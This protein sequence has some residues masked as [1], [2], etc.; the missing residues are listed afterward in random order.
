MLCGGV[1][2]EVCLVL[3]D[4]FC[5]VLNRAGSVM[6]IEDLHRAPHRTL[7]AK[8]SGQAPR[9]QREAIR[10]IRV[11]TPCS[12]ASLGRAAH[13]SGKTQT[14]SGSGK[15]SGAGEGI[16]TLDPNLGKVVLY[17]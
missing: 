5:A 4:A 2:G 17:P 3:E 6:T 14:L 15:K 7:P 1:I 8:H 13:L 16:R 10:T 11:G 12:R 9:C